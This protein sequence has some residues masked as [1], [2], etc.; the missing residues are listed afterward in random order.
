MNKLEF[1]FNGRRDRKRIK[2]VLSHTGTEVI[3]EEGTKVPKLNDFIEFYSLQPH[4]VLFNG[5]I[6]NSDFILRK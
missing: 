1:V 2:V 6:K 3:E 4:P 5:V